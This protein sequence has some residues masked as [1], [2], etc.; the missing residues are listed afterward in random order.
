MRINITQHHVSKKH[1]F[2][3]SPVI[4]GGKP[5]F[6]KLDINPEL[7]T[8]EILILLKELINDI[9]KNDRI[10]E[11]KEIDKQGENILEL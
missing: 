7:S 1:V 6:I 9:E 2:R 8:D 3:Y 10:K 5:K 4:G 11:T